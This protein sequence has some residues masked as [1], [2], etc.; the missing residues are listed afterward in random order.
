M[1]PFLDMPGYATNPEYGQPMKKLKGYG[2][3]MT[4]GGVSFDMVS[5]TIDEEQTTTV[6]GKG[7]TAPSP[8]A[9][10]AAFCAT[11]Q[12]CTTA[13]PR[14]VKTCT[15]ADIYAAKFLVD[16]SPT[17]LPKRIPLM[18]AEF[19]AD[20]WHERLKTMVEN[21]RPILEVVY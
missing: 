16:M 15:V 4:L 19:E 3:K 1:N 10:P 8:L 5:W 7:F 9:L 2:G 13:D 17:R 6:V 20:C 18:M 14:R 12:T 11:G 21:N